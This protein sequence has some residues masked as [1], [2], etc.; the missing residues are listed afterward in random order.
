MRPFRAARPLRSPKPFAAF[1]GFCLVLGFAGVAAAQDQL[2]VAVVDVAKIFSD[3][4]KVSDF[5]AKIGEAHDAYQRDLDARI[6]QHHRLVE[7]AAQLDKELASPGLD[8]AAKADRQKQRENK[9]AETRKLERETAEFRVTRERGIRELTL[10]VRTQIVEDVMVVVN[11]RVETQHY[12][13][14]LNPERPGARATGPCCSTPPTAWTSPDDVLATLKPRPSARQ[15]RR[16]P[17]PRRRVE[18]SPYAAVD[19]G[20]RVGYKQACAEASRLARPRSR[21]ERITMCG[22][23]G[24]IGKQTGPARVDR[25]LAPAGIPRLRLGGPRAGRPRGRHPL[26]PQGR[27]P[28]VPPSKPSWAARPRTP[29]SASPTPAG[30]P[31]AA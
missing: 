26:D 30:P 5:N 10:R 9:F 17:A 28:R 20:G 1:L 7:E 12:D 24:F 11:A 3:Y 25:R 18:R 13:L 19:I 2:R 4:Y 23:V 14:V 16:P 31:T 29:G 15:G 8:A 22:I 6:E 21:D 27:G